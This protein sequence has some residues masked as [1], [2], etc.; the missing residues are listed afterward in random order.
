MLAP[1]QFQGEHVQALGSSS[2]VQAC[3]LWSVLLAAGKSFHKVLSCSSFTMPH[4]LNKPT[5]TWQWLS[6]VCSCQLPWAYAAAFWNHRA[7]IRHLAEKRLRFPPVF[8]AE[9]LDRVV[10][11][12]KAVRVCVLIQP[13]SSVEGCRRVAQMLLS[14]CDK[15]MGLCHLL[16]WSLLSNAYG[17]RTIMLVILASWFLSLRWV[18]QRWLHSDERSS[19]G[20]EMARAE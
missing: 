5:K 4:C 16:T 19:L 1:L 12:C 13:K 14:A 10:A 2:V 20:C 18:V 11:S 8:H 3:W 6:E 7:S 17:E 9:H 15:Y